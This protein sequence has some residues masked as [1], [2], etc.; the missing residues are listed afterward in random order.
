MEN[1]SHIDIQTGRQTDKLLDGGSQACKQADRPE[2]SRGGSKMYY[3]MGRQHMD[4]GT[5]K[6]LIFCI[7]GNDISKCRVHISLKI[8]RMAPY[9][10]G[11]MDSLSYFQAKHNQA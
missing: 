6:F 7:I 11:F 4:K 10:I 9:L 8:I 1:Y 2:G 5:E 3:R